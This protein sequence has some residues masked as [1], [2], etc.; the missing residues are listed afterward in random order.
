MFTGL[1]QN[2]GKIITLKKSGDALALC[3]F[4]ALPAKHFKKG[5]SIAVDG[6]CLTVEKYETK[7]KYFW[8]TAVRETL[9]KTQISALSAGDTVHL[10]PP[11]TLETALGGHLVSGHV[12]GRAVV[13]KPAPHL[14][15]QL[16]K[17]LL[18]FCPVKGS[19]AV[20][21][22]SLTIAA[23]EENWVEMALIPETLKATKLGAL[24]RGDLCH[25]E[26]D[27]IA[28]YLEHLY[29]ASR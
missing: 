14:R 13:L 24:K 3:I 15:L 10:E 6:V 9:K 12:D 7:K 11:L 18:H 26:V 17:E 4:S 21:G 27:M 29:A 23:A 28:R 8:V 1:V 16:P 22:V 5:A 20:L 19:I 25:V 2:L